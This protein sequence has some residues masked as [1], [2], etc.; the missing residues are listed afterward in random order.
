MIRIYTKGNFKQLE[1]CCARYDGGWWFSEDYVSG[2]RKSYK[3]IQ[4]IALSD[5]ADSAG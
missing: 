5:S 1:G 2:E 3:V 4:R